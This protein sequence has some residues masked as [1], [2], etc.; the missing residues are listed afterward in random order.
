MIVMHP[1]AIAVRIVEEEDSSMMSQ[2]TDLLVN[3]LCHLPVSNEA[4]VWS[5]KIASDCRPLVYSTWKT[6]LPHTMIFLLVRHW[7][8][9]IAI[10]LAEQL[11][12]VMP[13]LPQLAHQ[14]PALRIH[15]SCVSW[16]LWVISW[17]CYPAIFA[18]S[19]VLKST[20]RISADW[21]VPSE[22]L[23]MAMDGSKSSHPCYEIEAMRNGS[24]P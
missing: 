22:L 3:L 19:Q 8:L 16:A 4:P 14:M 13:Q 12:I 7:Q 24:Y 5:Q 2:S 9:V 17:Q 10:D 21:D 20:A 18:G 15:S 1:R 6:L 23:S 11:T